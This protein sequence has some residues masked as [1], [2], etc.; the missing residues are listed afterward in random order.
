[1]KAF[2]FDYIV[3]YADGTPIVVVGE[4][5][6]GASLTTD[7]ESFL[8]DGTPKFGRYRFKAE[9]QSS[10]LVITFANVRAILRVER[11]DK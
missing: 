2:E 5:E 3:H 10:D 8:C 6:T 7:F 1:M 9:R 11:V 4:A